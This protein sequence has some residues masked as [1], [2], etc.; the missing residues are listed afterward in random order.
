MPII[1]VPVEKSKGKNPKYLTERDVARL[2]WAV[3]QVRNIFGV[4]T[5]LQEDDK[6]MPAKTLEKSIER[7]HFNS[8]KSS[9]RL[10][11][12]TD[13]LTLPDIVECEVSPGKNIES[14]ES[15]KTW[16]ILF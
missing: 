9:Y 2:A 11:S 10:S 1:Q 12:S 14:F 16:V 4:G 6:P 8:S 15:L 5:P 13:K 3:D 7:K